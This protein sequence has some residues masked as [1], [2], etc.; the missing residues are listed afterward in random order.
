VMLCCLCVYE[1][2]FSKIKF[3]IQKRFRGTTY[4]PSTFYSRVIIL[5]L[6]MEVNLP[7]KFYYAKIKIQTK[8]F[9]FLYLSCFFLYYNLNHIKINVIVVV[10]HILFTQ[11][12]WLFFMDSNCARI[13]VIKRLLH[14]S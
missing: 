2:S 8:I 3:A 10:A 9:S 11:K 6:Y 4:Y 5:Y 1:C 14:A 12:I 7:N 13:L